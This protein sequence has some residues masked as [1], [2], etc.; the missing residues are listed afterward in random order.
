MSVENF[1]KKYL[2]CV[3]GSNL[4]FLREKCGVTQVA[5]GKACGV[6]S[7]QIQKYESGKNK[8]SCST[9]YQISKVFNVSPIAFFEGLELDGQS[10][11]KTIYKKNDMELL[12][13]F[14]TI[15]DKM[16]KSIKSLLQSQ[17]DFSDNSRY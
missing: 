4:K 5:L 12:V 2:D 9:L 8:I 6:T 14:N 3:I 1:E 15:P 11:I 7:Q 13:L 17:S 16:K 10:S